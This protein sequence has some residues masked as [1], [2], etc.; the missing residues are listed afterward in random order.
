MGMVSGYRQADLQLIPHQTTRHMRRHI[1]GSKKEAQRFTC[2]RQRNGE[3]LDSGLVVGAIK[4][5]L[6]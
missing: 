4:K 6:I 5:E 2:D 3:V 1:A